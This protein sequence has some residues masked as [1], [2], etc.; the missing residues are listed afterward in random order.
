MCWASSRSPVRTARSSSVTMPVRRPPS[1]TGRRRMPWRTMS[2]AASSTFMPG[3]AVTTG[4][5]ACASAGSVGSRPSVRAPSARSRSVTKPTIAPSSPR[6]TT[7]PTLRSR[8][9]S[10]TSRAVAEGCAVT[11]PSVM[12]SRISTTAPYTCAVPATADETLADEARRRTQAG[13]VAIA[14][15]LLT[16]VSGALAAI[17]YS[18]KPTI[19]LI[20]ALR[21]HLSANAP[22]P[23]LKVRQALFYDTHAVTVILVSVLLALAAIAMGLALSHLYRSTKARRPE[24]PG[25]AIVTVITGA[26]VVAVSELAIAISIVVEVHKLAGSAT[27][28]AAAARDAL[29]PPTALLGGV[30]RQL[31][32][33]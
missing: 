33:I 26:S 11:T 21:E 25:I 5:D 22:V 1:R 29:Q 10:A 4:E 16:I 3:S 31:G 20:D 28:T 2:S 24:L 13:A 27:Q 14:A 23:G 17:V 9:S 8:M 30:L 7:E 19:A 12:T 18:D 32:V 15:G 6:S